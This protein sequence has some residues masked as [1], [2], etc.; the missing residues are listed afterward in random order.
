MP[1]SLAATGST[2][3]L[4]FP[5]ALIAFW[6][7]PAI[8]VTTMVSS[9]IAAGLDSPPAG[10]LVFA[11]Y[12]AAAGSAATGFSRDC[13]G[14][15][16]ADAAWVVLMKNKA[17]L[18]ATGNGRMRCECRCTKSAHDGC[19]H[20]TQCSVQCTPM[21][22]H[23]ILAAARAVLDRD[24]VPG[25]TVRKVAA[26]A[27]LSPM[28]M[29]RHFADKSALL[30]ALMDDGLAA[31]DEIASSLTARHPIAWLQE[32]T[33]AFLDFALTKPHR[34]DAAFFLPAPNARRFPDDFA[35]GRS[36][37]MA[38]VILRIDQAKSDGWLGNKPALEVA[39]S[40]AA[41]AQGLVSMHRGN[42]FSSEEQFKTIFRTALRHC[43]ESY[44][45]KPL[46]R[47]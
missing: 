43:L 16:W 23:R 32:L 25:L 29:Y 47:K 27:K 45:V 1:M 28:A 14:A 26:R 40:L 15:C 41:L 44:S 31:W 20:C 3:S 5:F 30:D 6:I 21:T 24:G 11:P 17:A 10:G 46:G 42:R 7:L 35:A 34:F 12:N 9:S 36:P 33:E 38:M 4:E 37:V 18:H 2:I 19:V 39:L 22:R 13:Y 8:P